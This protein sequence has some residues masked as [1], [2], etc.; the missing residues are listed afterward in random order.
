MMKR[1]GFLETKR[2]PRYSLRKFSVGMVSV[3][4]GVTIFGINFTN[5]SVKAATTESVES[6]N[7]SPNS[8][9]QQTKG[10]N[11]IGA[12]K[13]P[14]SQNDANKAIYDALNNKKSEINGATN[15]D[16]TTKDKLNQ[17]ATD[18][19]DKAKEGITKATTNNDVATEQT[20][21]QKA[22]SATGKVQQSSANNNATANN[23][24]ED[25]TTLQSA[26]KT[27]GSAGSGASGS[28]ATGVV[29]RSQDSNSQVA[30][31]TS[32]GANASQAA[33]E[34]QVP[35][36]AASQS[37]E[38]ANSGNAT[39]SQASQA[40]TVSANH[41]AIGTT[42]SS[43]TVSVNETTS[44]ATQARTLMRTLMTNLAVIN[45][46]TA[47]STQN[48][49][50]DT[51][52]PTT[53]QTYT[54]V[55][56][57]LLYDYGLHVS[58]TGTRDGQTWVDK[59]VAPGTS[60]FSKDY[61]GNTLN[62]IFGKTS[63]PGTGIIGSKPDKY[64]FAAYVDFSE[65]YHRVILLARSQDLS[66]KN[67]Y[68]YTIHTYTQNNSTTTIKPGDSIK[69][70]YTG[71]AGS[72]GSKYD[73]IFHNYG[74]SFTVKLNDFDGKWGMLPV[75]DGGLLDPTYGSN[76]Y[77]QNDTAAQ[78]EPIS[79]WASAIPQETSTKVRYVD[80]ATG[81]DIVQP[82]EISGFGYQGFKVKGEAPTVTGYHLVSK[83]EFLTSK[84]SAYEDGTI[85]PYQ[86]GQ[87]YDLALS[88]SVVIKQTVI[89]TD[90]TVRATAY[91][92]G[93]RIP[94]TSASKVLGRESYNDKMSFGAPD[95]K[96]YT[97]TNRIGQV[98][99]SYI[100][101]YAKNS[102]P[103]G[104]DM[105]LHFIDVTGV[106]NSSYAPSDGPE[107]DVGKVQT[108]HGNIPDNYSFT[109]T[110][111]KGYDQVAA[112]G[113]TGT[114]SKTRH[115]AYVYVKKQAENK[116]YAPVASDPLTVEQGTTLTTGQA[117]AA[118]KYNGDVPSD[119]T[120]AWDPKTPVDT[121][122]VG[123]Y[124]PNVIVTYGDHT[125]SSVPVTVNVVAKTDKSNYT[126]TAGQP[127]TLTHGQQVKAGDSLDSSA[128]T[129]KDAKGQPVSLPDKAKVVWTNAPDTSEVGND[130]TGQAKVVYGDN[131]E[132]E[133]VT[134]TYN[135]TPNDAETNT[136]ELIT[137]AAD[138][139]A[140]VAPDS[141]VTNQDKLP[142]GTTYSW[143]TK[144]DTSK[145]G[146]QATGS[147]HVAYPDGSSED[148]P[149]KVNV[150]SNADQ[151]TPTVPG[152][153]VTVKDPSHL[154]DDEKNQVKNNVDNANKDKFPDGTE[155][156]VGDNGTATVTYP[157]GSKDTIPGDQLVQGQKGGTTDA[158]NIT[159]TV[160]GG[161]VT[162]KDPS[163][164]TEGEKD[165][166]KTNVTNANKD[167]FPAGTEVAVGDDGTA[168]VTYPD[169]S[170]DTIPG[171]QLVQGQKGDTTDAGKITPTVPG[172]KVTVKDPGHLTDDEKNQVKNNVDNANKDKFP[173][174]TKVTVGND[175]TA[176]IT[177]PDTSTDTIKGSN[178]VSP[179][180]DAEKI[181]PT[182]P[183]DKVTV[184]DPSHLTDDEKNQVKNNVDNANKDKFPAGTEV[185]VGDDGTATVTYPDGS[186]NT[187]PGHDLVTGK[188]DAD[189]YPLN[190]GQAVDVVDPNHLTQAEQDQVKEAIR[191]ANPTAPIATITVDTAGNVQV[192]FADGSTTTLQA[193]LHKHVTEVTTGSATK[194]GAGTNGNQMKGATST[195]QTA[196]KQQAQQHLPQTGD[197]P[198]MWAMLSGL[199]VAFLGLLGLKKKRE[200]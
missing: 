69:E 104:S 167:K 89:N 23:S 65:Q 49:G 189:K 121:A 10:I 138:Q 29:S 20:N 34:T 129:L 112:S 79:F 56:Q 130:K 157:D 136:P 170:K 183:G 131:S 17:A 77:K 171:D 148:V 142:K 39:S 155:V 92:K 47:D 36:P 180:K 40:G 98:G 31:A 158:G 24:T 178:L 78:T 87:T 102:D 95:G 150:K 62:T 126:V 2:T 64:F 54:K 5:H 73:L 67:L 181:K 194:P 59:T 127:V 100:Y 111:P 84:A 161:K 119:A 4:L 14:D 101:Y 159:P 197:Q 200:D 35:A 113:V 179:E 115:D 82:M 7:S 80:Q 109:Y 19:A 45:P 124:T 192:T 30:S 12:V 93:S 66:D 50:P 122:T 16:Q 68:S 152:D 182:V 76:S 46:D 103:H 90:G 172:D 3:L 190:P 21:T 168:T 169:G 193:N 139:N 81:K 146:Q 91:Y 75:F 174:G 140:E 8:N 128:V 43:Q 116:L 187:I 137:Q 37:S 88:D 99:D 13:V 51:K 41:T 153:K 97:Y 52:L 11:A 164:L 195:N 108:I 22:T 135:V 55:E 32:S 144:P 120:Y 83:P 58:V 18:A 175:G 44:S 74:D 1:L 184:K 118:V 149:V 72:G 6:S 60:I 151:Y 165:Q 196:T 132:S 123:S 176:T 28:S 9:S 57:P 160:P 42:P 86:V 114:Y 38:S 15:I 188:T 191:T 107:L 70:Q 156:T 154:T 53:T 71:V 143:T 134:V 96:F 186:T 26:P 106:N 125:T 105:R 61:P 110:V 133:P 166:V 27:Q 145:A 141:V 185:T 173:D 25:A 199:G 163:H 94:S 198:A 33:P 177:Y 147:L 48:S 85:S 63:K 162:V 117:K